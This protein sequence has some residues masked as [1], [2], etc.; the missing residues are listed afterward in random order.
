ML[1][2]ASIRVPLSRSSLGT[3]R[4]LGFLPSSLTKLSTLSEDGP[5]LTDKGRGCVSP[6]SALD[7]D[8]SHITSP[9]QQK[10]HGSQLSCS[11]STQPQESLEWA[12]RLTIPPPLPSPLLLTKSAGVCFQFTEHGC[13]ACM[14]VEQSSP[15]SRYYLF[16][17]CTAAVPSKNK[18][19]FE[20]EV[21]FNFKNLATWNSREVL[22]VHFEP[23]GLK[24]S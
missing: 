13:P 16:T 19:D 17:C 18:V 24:F 3:C 6:L 14:K 5:P 9:W 7:I 11:D 8:T 20:I 22:T 15:K 10:L 2:L 12:F 23:L 4:W 1:F 21:N